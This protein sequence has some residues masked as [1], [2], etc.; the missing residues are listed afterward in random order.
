MLAG[1][2]ESTTGHAII[3]FPAPKRKGGKDCSRRLSYLFQWN[4]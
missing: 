4:K 1:G 2:V 3:A